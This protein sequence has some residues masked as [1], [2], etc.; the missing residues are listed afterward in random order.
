MNTNYHLLQIT[1]INQDSKYRMC[2]E[3]NETSFHI[4]NM[5]SKLTT[6]NYLKS[7]TNVAAIL[8]R[9]ICQHCGI[10]TSKTLYKRH[11]EP[12]IENKEDKA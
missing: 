6:N 9:K 8:H 2:K 5:F 12:V 7:H 4:G 10:K 11:P 1:G 3:T